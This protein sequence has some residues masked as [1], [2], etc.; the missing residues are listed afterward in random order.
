[1]KLSIK[2]KAPERALVKNGFFG[3]QEVAKKNPGFRSFIDEAAKRRLY[4][5]EGT[6]FRSNSRNL[7]YNNYIKN[8]IKSV[9]GLLTSFS[10]FSNSKERRFVDPKGRF[11][12]INV[13][14][15]LENRGR[16]GYKGS[17]NYDLNKAH[18]M[19]QI[20]SRFNSYREPLSAHIVCSI[21]SGLPRLY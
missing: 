17:E 3:E 6:I 5:V 21:M 13:V 2:R 19:N 4:H 11:E 18:I 7:I 16:I 10:K 9:P 8:I 14:E 20:A 15:Q 12:I 1:M